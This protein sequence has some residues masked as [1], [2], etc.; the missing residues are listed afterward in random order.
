MKIVPNS[1]D[2]RTP[3]VLVTGLDADA[4]ARSAGALLVPGTTVVHH[5]LTEL[6]LGRV[7]RTLRTVDDDGQ[8]RAHQSV[9]LLEHGCISCTLRNDLL[10]LLR[11]LHR[12]DTVERIV[13]QLDSALEPEAL[14]WAI[15]QAIVSD[16]PGLPDA[17]AGEDV[18][19]DATIACIHEADWLEAATGDTT[20]A[21]AGLSA[22]TGDE[23]E[24]TLAQ[25]A[26]G[27]VAFADA[28]VI[29]GC[30][31]AMRDAWASARLTAVLKRLAPSA[32]IIMEIPQ[33]PITTMLAVQLLS[34]IPAGSR[35]G[36]IDTPHD[37]LL[38]GEPPLDSDCGV[39]LFTFESD[40]PFHPARLHE[41]I[42][43]LLEG[44]V[45]S[46]G[47][48]WLATQP[49]SAL[50]VESAGGGLR[51]A[52]GAPWLAAMTEDELAAVDPELRALA[53][54]RWD[55]HYGDRHTSMAILAHRPG[56][57]D[58]IRQALS[59]ACLTDEEMAVGKANWLSFDDPFGLAHSDPCDDLPRAVDVELTN[60]EDNR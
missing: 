49:D 41:A 6:D 28:L 52:E 59:E 4:V 23:D 8:E 2:G 13:L 18:R 56:Q 53:A 5:D 38:R 48:M 3:I 36:H 44:V 30:D 54:L 1:G 58:E 40:R 29:V 46:R 51:V 26:V 25:V 16:M 10:P 35:R 60:R 43:H 57:P 45:C 50:W 17:P 39:E 32:P 24:R 27:Q 33:R 20:M 15:D 7:R 11:Q 22:T 47:R 55:D 12:R 42:D 31:A 37:P 9:L 19:I 34:A 21:E 14:S